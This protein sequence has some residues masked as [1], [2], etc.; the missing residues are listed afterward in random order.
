M[1]IVSS[2]QMTITDLNDS[3]QIVSYIGASQSKTVIHN[4][5]D[6]SYTPNYSVSNQTLTPQLFIAGTNTNIIGDAKSIK[7]Y[8][9]VNGGGTLTEITVSDSTYTL[10]TN[11]VISSNV[12]TSNNSMAYV[13]EIV[14]TDPS[15]GFDITTKSDIELVKVSNGEKGQDGYTPVKGTDYFDGQDGADGTSSY[16]WIRYSQNSDGS[17]MTTNPAGAIYIGTATTQTASAPT[18]NTSYSWSLIKGEDGIAGENGTDGQTSYLHIKYSNDGGSTFTGNNGEDVGDW[19]GTYVDFTQADS[20]TPAD[21]TWNKTKGDKGED[22]VV[23]MVWTPNGNIIK[24]EEGTLTAEVT[25]Y[26]GSSQVNGTAFKWYVQDPTATTSSGGDIDGG[27]GWRK[28]TSTYNIGTTGYTTKTLTVPASAI[29]SVESFKCVVTYDGNK[30][31]DVCTMTDVSDPILVVV[32]GVST[33]KNGQGS[34]NFTAKLFRNGAE[35]DSGGTEYTYTWSLYNSTN[36]L[37]SAFGSP[38]GKTITVNASDIEVRASLVCD[39]SK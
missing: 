18:S 1:A 14:Y 34:S 12:L 9:Q 10:G 27:N 19:I 36:T 26:K 11:L 17:G 16:L 28:L 6:N 22:S 38:T 30:Y 39:V 13:C 20:L 29:P 5:N 4:P 35:I 37:I 25:L 33:F 7:W 15:T 3:K 2:G 32:N 23:A 8:Y 21:Y 31:Q 24:N